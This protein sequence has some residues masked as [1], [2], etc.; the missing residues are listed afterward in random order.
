MLLAACVT[1]G[2]GSQG[3]ADLAGSY[4]D[5]D[6]T[7]ATRVLDPAERPQGAPSAHRATPE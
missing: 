5:I 7:H 6:R 1:A 2:A 4:G 3:G